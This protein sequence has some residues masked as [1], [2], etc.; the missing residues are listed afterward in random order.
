M[1]NYR[2][3]KQKK[4]VIG[5][6]LFTSLI[7][8]GL[9]LFLFFKQEF[10]ITYYTNPDQLISEV[11]VGD[12]TG[13]NPGCGTNCKRSVI[14]CEAKSTQL[15]ECLWKLSEN[16]KNGV[17]IRFPKSKNFTPGVG[18][19]WI[20]KVIGKQGSL[21]ITEIENVRDYIS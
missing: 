12:I 21:L 16:S 9:I 1:E 4:I 10:V 20:V 14:S 13:I 17:I 3:L 6:G 8:I 19:N 15:S 2:R 5:I 7:I 11:S 18:T